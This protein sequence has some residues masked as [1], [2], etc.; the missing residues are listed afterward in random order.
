MSKVSGEAYR[1]TYLC[2]DSYERGVMRGRWY[3]PGL[4][5]GGRSFES[6]AQFLTGAEALFDAGNFPQ[7]YMAKR[8]FVPIPEMAAPGNLDLSSQ[9]GKRGTFMIRLLFRQHASWQGCVTWIESSSEQTFRS[10]L[11]LILLIDSALGGCGEV[12]A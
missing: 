10:A 2:V 11:E 12:S 1:T 5:G 3:N 7:S 8:V 4:E 9:T 6:L